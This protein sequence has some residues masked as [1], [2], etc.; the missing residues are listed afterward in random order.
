[1]SP[2]RLRVMV[3]FGTRPEVI[4]LAL[5]IAELRR[6]SAAFETVI[7]ATAQHR[8]MLDQTLSIFDL[9]PDI[10]LD[11][12]R[13]D[14]SLSSLGARVLSELDSVMVDVRP[15][16]TLVQGDT[17]TVMMAALAAQHRQVRV[18]HVEAGLRTFDRMNPFPEEMNRVVT[19]HISDLLFPPT[20]AA[21]QHLLREGID[22]SR[23]VVTGNTGID[24]LLSVASSPWRPAPPSP[25][26]ALPGHKQ[27]ILVTAH[28]RENHGAPLERICAGLRQIA[29]ERRDQV[30]IVYPVHRNPKVW[31]PVHASLS[32][33][34]GITLLPPVDYREMVFLLQNSTLALTDSGGLQEECP[35]LGKPALV[36]RETTERPEAVDAGIARVI[37]T[38]PERIVAE[39]SRL[40]DDPDDY[41]SMVAKNNPFGDG[42]ASLRIVDALIATTR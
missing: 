22:A 30:E 16:W 5:V 6:R 10:D 11:I 36:L 13:P 17:T 27:W 38:V 31:D 39:V 26:A 35:S 25:C 19:D 2:N 23:I 18:G 37:G 34:D 4:K 9:E 32:D 33:V 29:L 28:R 42:K 24:A 15:D 20:P 1:M 21:R 14:Q 41:A 3:V 7:C 40:L 8:E 12:M